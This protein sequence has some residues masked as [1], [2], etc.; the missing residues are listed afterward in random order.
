M[1]GDDWKDKLDRRTRQR[2]DEWERNRATWKANQRMKLSQRFKKIAADYPS[3]V[4]LVGLIIIAAIYY[5]TRRYEVV[6]S[7]VEWMV[8]P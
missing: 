7:V 1:H 5:G 2:L 8:K 4:F 6:E 3:V